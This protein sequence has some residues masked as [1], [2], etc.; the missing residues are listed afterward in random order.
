MRPPLTELRK[1]IQSQI[2]VRLKDGKEYKGR[3]EQIDDHMNLV[4]SGCTEVS[5]DGDP[6]KRIGDV[7]LR[8]NNIMFIIL[9]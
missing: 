3:L 4:L 2:T 7:F 6:V 8:G 5:C 1:A 9:G